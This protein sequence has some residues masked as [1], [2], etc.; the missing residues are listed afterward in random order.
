MCAPRC[1]RII[2]MW[3]VHVEASTELGVELRLDRAYRDVLVV[4]GPVDAVEMRRAVEDVVAPTIAPRASV[5]H[6]V[7]GGHHG[8]R[9]VDHC[10]V[11]HLTFTGLAGLQDRTEQSD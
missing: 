9:P 11:E 6:A 5:H 7:V 2:I 4:S 1:R 10:D 3:H 8:R